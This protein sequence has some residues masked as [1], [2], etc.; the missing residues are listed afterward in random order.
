M[1]RDLTS[2]QNTKRCT[3]NLNQQKKFPLDYKR[4]CNAFCCI[5]DAVH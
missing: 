4:V 5:Y 1:S 2:S 3:N